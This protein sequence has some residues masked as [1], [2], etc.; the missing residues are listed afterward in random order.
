MQF[1]RWLLAQRGRGDTV[2]DLARFAARDKLFP[3]D[4]RLHVILLR[5][6]GTPHRNAAKLAHREWRSVRA[7]CEMERAS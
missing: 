7:A 4:S 2:G 1:Y 3:R 6:D 5:C